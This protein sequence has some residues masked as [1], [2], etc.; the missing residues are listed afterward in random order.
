MKT[1]AEYP[2]LLTM[3]EVADLFRSNAA[4]RSRAGR[5]ICA[6]HRIQVVQ[7]HRPGI[8]LAPKHAIQSVIGLPAMEEAS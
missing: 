6:T 1:L 8:W 5:N 7:G 4:N 2:D 3:S